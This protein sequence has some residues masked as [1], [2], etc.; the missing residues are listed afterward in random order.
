MLHMACHIHYLIR[1]E[2]VDILWLLRV[3]CNDWSETSS[4]RTQVTLSEA[5]STLTLCKETHT[6]F[7]FGQLLAAR[8]FAAVVRF[9]I[10]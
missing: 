7:L 9:S 5:A 4:W 3:G 1:F 6:D 2:V 10:A 8:P